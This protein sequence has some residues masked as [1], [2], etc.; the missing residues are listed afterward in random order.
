MPANDNQ[1][2]KKTLMQI[3]GGILLII[4]VGGGYTL[5]NL[6]SFTE[7]SGP[8]P[9]RNAD[10]SSSEHV[11]NTLQMPSIP[12]DADQATVSYVHD[13]DTIFIDPIELGRHLDTMERTKVRLIGIDAPEVTKPQECFGEEATRA[14]RQLLPEKSTIWVTTDRDPYDR[15][16]RMLLYIWNSDGTFV[17]GT[18]V[19][20]GYAIPLTIKPN[21]SFAPL[22]SEAVSVAQ[23]NHAGMWQACS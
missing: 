15:Y 2:Q 17:N 4:V 21:T 23:T 5:L 3:I 18:L 12:S 13:G 22:F 9:V 14:L 20:E 19:E 6:D 7:D 8:Q 1:P 16:D 10:Q 11:A